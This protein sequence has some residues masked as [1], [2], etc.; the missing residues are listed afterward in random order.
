M[1]GIWLIT[2]EASHFN[3]S[4]EQWMSL[5]RSVS[6][7]DHGLLESSPAAEKRTGATQS[8]YLCYCLGMRNLLRACVCLSLV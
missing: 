3:N 1:A 8:R 7:L 5:L 6:I 4:H 2:T